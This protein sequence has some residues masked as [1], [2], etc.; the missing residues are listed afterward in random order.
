MCITSFIPHGSKISNFA[1]V[2]TDNTVQIFSEFSLIWAAKMQGNVPVQLVICNLAKQKGLIASCDD[3]GMLKL[4][5][6]GT[7]PPVSNVSNYSRELDY[8]KIDE[9]HKSLLQTIR[10]S[11]NESK[12]DTYEKLVI[13][14]QLGNSLERASSYGIELPPDV[15]SLSTAFGFDKNGY[16]PFLKRSVKVFLSMT[17]NK[18]IS[19]ITLTVDVPSYLHVVPSSI[20]LEQLNSSQLN[21]SPP[22]IFDFYPTKSIF[23]TSITIQII[24]TYINSKG[25]P[26][27][28]VLSMI[29]PLILCCRAKP[30]TKS[31][32]HKI[33]IDTNMKDP[34]L[35]TD[36]FDDFL[37]ANSE[38]GNFIILL[39]YN[40]YIYIY[41][42]NLKK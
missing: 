41:I 2:N 27:S 13:K 6:L 36:L 9:E 39:I 30:P 21:T 26:Q 34:V 20:H 22:I 24:A 25:E 11:Q 7:K 8:D 19:N 38:Y 10:N 35:L 32:A 16:N 17:G 5:Y 23:P 1:I 33:V 14:T 18:S 4:N 28:S 3:E 40:I 29:L 31:A 37:L 15:I 42:S 12:T